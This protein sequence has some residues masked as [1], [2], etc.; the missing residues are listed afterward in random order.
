MRPQGEYDTFRNFINDEDVGK[1]ENKEDE[2]VDKELVES[3]NDRSIDEFSFTD[4]PTTNPIITHTSTSDVTSTSNSDVS[5]AI[6]AS[7]ID[8][9]VRA[10]S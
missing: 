8:A 9:P 4:N 5:P 10:S 6:V 2:D 7:V 1:E 3:P